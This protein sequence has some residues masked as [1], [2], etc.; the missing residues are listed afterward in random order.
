MT[1]IKR[2]DIAEF[3]HKGYLHEINRL[4][5]HPL[6][7]AMEITL[8]KEPTVRV[9]FKLEDVGALLDT[10]KAI[11]EHGV[12]SD[13]MAALE[14]RL[15]EAPV[16][17]RGTEL[18]GGVWDSRD[19]PKGFEYGDDLLDWQKAAFVADLMFKRRKA[20]QQLLGY[21]VQPVE[22][23]RPTLTT[24]YIDPAERTGQPCERC[25]GQLGAGGHGPGFCT[26]RR[27]E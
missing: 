8:V 11:R 19:D 15:L 10:I 23:E 17:H 12:V 27:S 26:D 13:E 25:G 4:L 21:V 14:K 20:R 2:I 18:L 7:L 6:G 22:T 9:D 1:D 16:L 5:L 24:T 3:R